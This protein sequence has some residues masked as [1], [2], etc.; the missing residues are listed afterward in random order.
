[1]SI[2]EVIVI[3]QS[4]DTAL[5]A[6][7]ADTYRVPVDILWIKLKLFKGTC[8]FVDTDDVTEEMLVGKNS[9]LD[10]EE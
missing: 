1:M 9:W 3:V 6:I 7:G 4:G 10:F 2:V 8:T 5:I